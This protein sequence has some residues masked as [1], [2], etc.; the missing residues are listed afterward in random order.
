MKKIAVLLLISFFFLKNCYSQNS[1]H[2]KLKG[3]YFAMSQVENYETGDPID[4][5]YYI[6]F[7]ENYA[8]LNF[9]DNTYAMCEGKYFYEEKKNGLL[10]LKRD[11]NDG[12]PCF[13]I[14]NK[15]DPNDAEIIYVKEEKKEFYIK[16]RRFYEQKWKKLIKK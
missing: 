8:T 15:N 13:A 4:V 9:S 6:Y 7:N 12:R 16:S 2:N 11:K 3:M 5:V 10:L 1:I 14:G